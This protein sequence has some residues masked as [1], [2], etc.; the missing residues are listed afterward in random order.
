[1]KLETRT[2]SLFSFR[3][4]TCGAAVRDMETNMALSWGVGGVFQK[5]YYKN[6]SLRCNAHEADML[7][8]ASQLKRSSFSLQLFCREKF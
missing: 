8:S 1:M 5:G 2:M 6:L 3:S 4:M 7:M